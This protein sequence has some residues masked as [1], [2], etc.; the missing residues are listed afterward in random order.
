MKLFAAS[1]EAPD[2]GTEP[3][4]PVPLGGTCDGEGNETHHSPLLYSP[5][6]P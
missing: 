5:C 1:K 6:V 3:G 2:K 4:L